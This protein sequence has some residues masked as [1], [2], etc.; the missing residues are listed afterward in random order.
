MKGRE[1][2]EIVSIALVESLTLVMEALDAGL[3][4]GALWLSVALLSRV[5]MRPTLRH[6]TQVRH[7]FNIWCAMTSAIVVSE[8][9]VVCVRCEEAA[10]GV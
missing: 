4:F 9:S 5:S 8:V 2:F 3:A 6:Q 7:C 10:S 1:G